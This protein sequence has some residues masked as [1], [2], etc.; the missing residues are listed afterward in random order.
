MGP[1]CKFCNRRCFVPFS[2]GTPKEALDAYSALAPDII[3]SIIA[4]C[5][6]GQAYEKEKTGWCYH[7]IQKAIKPIT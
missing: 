3:I 4:T 2:E 6:E 1:Y 7:D 5:A